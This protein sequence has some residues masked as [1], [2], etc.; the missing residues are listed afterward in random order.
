[1]FAASCPCRPLV[2]KRG[3]RA[4]AGRGAFSSPGGEGPRPI[5][6]L[7]ASRHPYAAGGRQ[8]PVVQAPPP[9][10]RPSPTTTRSGHLPAL[11]A[12]TPLT[13]LPSVVLL[14]GSVS[15]PG[16]CRPHAPGPL[17][18]PARSCRDLGPLPTPTLCLPASPAVTTPPPPRDQSV[19][20]S[21]PTPSEASHV[22]AIGFPRR[23]ALP[24]ARGR[25]RSCP[26]RGWSAIDGGRT[27]VGHRVHEQPICSWSTTARAAEAPRDLGGVGPTTDRHRAPP[28]TPPGCAGGPGRPGGGRPGRG[29]QHMT[30]GPG[31]FPVRSPDLHPSKLCC[32]SKAGHGRV[33]PAV[34]PALARRTYL[35]EPWL[36]VAASGLPITSPGRLG[37]VARASL[38]DGRRAALGTA[39]RAARRLTRMV[40]P[41]G[42]YG[43]TPPAGAVEEAG[44]DARGCR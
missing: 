27:A 9:R 16:G 29:G 36:P 14:P 15:W 33:Q 40:I 26:P 35:F 1:M 43:E 37:A 18:Q 13:G 11:A 12:L 17:A 44:E 4:P 32:W 34:G 39:A 22:R 21:S 6:A 20:T 10:R 7:A 25:T 31:S 19:L 8:R 23:L 42:W 5:L 3:V 2:I 41:H 28:R 38:G 24:A 30:E